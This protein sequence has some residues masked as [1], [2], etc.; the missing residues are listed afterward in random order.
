MSA[1]VTYNVI[2]VDPP[3]REVVQVF[4][5]GPP[6]ARGQSAVTLTAAEALA[7][8]ALVYVKSD[9][10]VANASAVAEGKEAV[11]FVKAG[12]APGAA[13]TVYLAG[14]VMAGLSG[15]TPG[16]AYYLSTTAGGIVD[17]ATAGA[18]A[19]GNVVLPIGT[20]L[21]TTELLFHPTTPITL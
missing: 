8:N 21:S 1:P 19:T 5:A 9:G 6:G 20:A 7:P 2:V 16:A 18:Y 13:A 11:G 4:T 10:T 3:Q 17:A 14:N 12:V 15:L